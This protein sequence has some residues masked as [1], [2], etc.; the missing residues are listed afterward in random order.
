MVAQEERAGFSERATDRLPLRRRAHEIGEL[1]EGGYAGRPKV[2][3][4]MRD[5][6]QFEPARREGQAEPRMGV[7]HGEDLGARS[8]DLGVDRE[9]LVEALP[10]VDPGPIELETDKMLLAHFVESDARPFHPERL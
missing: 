3:A 9:L 8:H 6:P 4:F 7:D 10:P 5:R 1:C 2:R